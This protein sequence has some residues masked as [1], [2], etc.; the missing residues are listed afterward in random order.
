M[1]GDRDWDLRSIQGL[2][3]LAQLQ[4]ILPQLQLYVWLRQSFVTK[5]EASVSYRENLW[6]SDIWMTSR[7]FRSM[8]FTLFFGGPSS[9]VHL[10]CSVGSG[11]SVSDKGPGRPWFFV[12]WRPWHSCWPAAVHLGDESSIIHQWS[13][14]NLLK[15]RGSRIDQHLP[16][17]GL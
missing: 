11:G 6:K 14:T 5:V 12:P 7:R 10:L 17:W 1:I 2:G 3:A 8:F 4:G 9:G 15:P 13:P 16:F